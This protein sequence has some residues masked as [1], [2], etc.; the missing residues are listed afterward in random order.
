[1][2][3]KLIFQIISV[4]LEQSSL[5]KVSL[6]VIDF[7]AKD[8]GS[9]GNKTFSGVQ[10]IF[11]FMDKQKMPTGNATVTYENPESAAR[12]IESKQFIISSFHAEFFS[13][14]SYSM[15]HINE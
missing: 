8:I 6:L 11:I 4:E 12:A 13:H 14:E 1:M 15:T 7:I 2:F 9:A 5:P 3:Q 10:R